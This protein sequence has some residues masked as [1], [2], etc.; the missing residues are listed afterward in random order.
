MIQN[1]TP[2]VSVIMSVYRTNNQFLRESIES[3]LNQTYKNFEFIIID[4]NTTA[5]NINIIKSYNDNRVK[6][7][8]NR[9]NIGL[10]KSLNKGIQL[11]KG[12][13]IARMDADDISELD[14][15]EK[16][17]AYMEKNPDVIVLGGYA[18]I[19]NTN[20]IFMPRIDDFEVVKIRMLFYN[21]ALVHPTAMIN[22]KMLI[23]YGIRYN[24]LINKSQDYM[25]WVDCM[26]VKKIEVLEDVVLQYRVH[27]NQISRASSAEQKHFAM[28]VQKRLLRPLFGDS[29]NDE[30]L[31]I[32]GSIVNGEFCTSL[33]K[34]ECYFQILMEKNRLTN[35]YNQEKFKRECYYMWLLMTF[36]SIVFFN[37]FKGIKSKLFW[38]ALFQVKYWLYYCKYFLYV[39]IKEKKLIY[40]KNKKVTKVGI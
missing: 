5:E 4:D 38:K 39:P 21:C 27:N 26:S 20:K 17:V 31:L 33:K 10:T 18:Q 36:K 34:Y 16:Q 22:R 7:I 35:L 32:N 12:K 14:R 29:L 15:F 24:E 9:H 30:I 6:L 40:R 8:H 11:A 37:N 25:L 2:L 19:L 1:F 3:I 23:D 13:Y 28:E